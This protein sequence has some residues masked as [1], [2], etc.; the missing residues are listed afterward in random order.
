MKREEC[1]H[2]LNSLSEYLDG[3][4]EEDLCAELEGHL[5]DCEDCRVV[6]DTLNKTVYLV[7]QSASQCCVPEDVRLRLFKQ[8]DLEEFIGKSQGGFSET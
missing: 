8:L 3:T 6:V 2:L 5:A 4:L 1:H 7:H